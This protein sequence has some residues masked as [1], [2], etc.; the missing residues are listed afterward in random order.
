[1]FC[2]TPCAEH[3][4]IA[5]RKKE[6][7][8]LTMEDLKSMTYTWQVVQ[9]TMR[10]TTIVPLGYRQATKDFQYNGY[11]ILKGWRVGFLS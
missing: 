1:M 7:E 6:G 11:T 2:L 9:E 8:P 4:P 10:Q 5:A 3:K